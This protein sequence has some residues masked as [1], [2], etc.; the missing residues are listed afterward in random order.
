MHMAHTVGHRTQWATHMPYG[1]R[2]CNLQVEVANYLEAK[3]IANPDFRICRWRWRGAWRSSICRTMLSS[4]STLAN[5]EASKLQ[6]EVEKYLEEQDLP[7]TVFQ[8]QYIYG[9]TPTRTASSGSSTASSGAA[10]P[11][12]KYTHTLSTSARP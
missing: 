3:Y 10:S 4:C 6:V 2:P 11:A 12:V 7:Y 5:H 1:V 8:P 9:P